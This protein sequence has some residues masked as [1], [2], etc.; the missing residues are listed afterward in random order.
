MDRNLLG[1]FEYEVIGHEI[2]IFREIIIRRVRN[3]EKLEI[4]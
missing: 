4:P 3:S 2:N 1:L